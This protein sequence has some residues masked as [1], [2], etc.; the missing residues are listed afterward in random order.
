MRILSKTRKL[1]LTGAASDRNQD[2]P[3]AGWQ[4][5]PDQLRDAPDIKAQFSDQQRL[6]QQLQGRP[7]A[8]GAPSSNTSHKCTQVYTTQVLLLSN[9]MQDDNCKTRD[10]HDYK[11]ITC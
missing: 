7:A 10:V 9:N 8:F 11:D 3:E 5:I 2:R 1:F 6:L 4:L